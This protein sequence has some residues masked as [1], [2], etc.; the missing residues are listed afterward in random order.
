M[1]VCAL[2]TNAPG[3]IA[4]NMRFETHA[5]CLTAL[6]L[7]VILVLYFRY[8]FIIFHDVTEFNNEMPLTEKWA[9]NLVILH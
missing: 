1:C 5:Q 9:F 3:F 7:G 6:P 2:E 8:A 4:Q